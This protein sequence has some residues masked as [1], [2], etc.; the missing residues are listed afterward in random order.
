MVL[1]PRVSEAVIFSSDRGGEL[2]YCL[3][4]TTL[5]PCITPL[6]RFLPRRCAQQGF[7]APHP[8]TTPFN[9]TGPESSR[10]RPAH[11]LQKMTRSCHGWRSFLPSLQLPSPPV[12]DFPP[13]NWTWNHGLT[14]TR[15]AKERA[16]ASPSPEPGFINAELRC[17]DPR[18]LGNTRS[19]LG[20]RSWQDDGLAFSN[21]SATGATRPV[22]CKK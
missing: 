17:V 5:R 14:D 18:A 11:R 1:D 12:G 13:T 9:T 16:M 2:H 3:L 10:R 7:Q 6:Q 4:N 20:S 21:L 19:F 8:A 15:H 22:W